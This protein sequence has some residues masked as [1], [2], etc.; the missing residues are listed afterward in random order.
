[1]EWSELPGAVLGLFGVDVPDVVPFGLGFLPLLVE[2]RD[3]GLIP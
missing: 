1:M 2:A 3:V